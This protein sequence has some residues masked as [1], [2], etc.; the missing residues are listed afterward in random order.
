MAVTPDGAADI[1]ARPPATGLR[2]ALRAFRH[3]DFAIFWSGALVSNTGTW[4]SNLAVPYVLFEIT[5]SVFWLGLAS[6]AQLIPALVLGPL[7][8]ALADRFDRRRILIVTQCCAATSALLMW[9]AWS[10][11]VRDPVVIL[12]LLGLTG[13]ILGINMPSWQSFVNDLVPREDL[14]SAVTLNSV[15]FNAARSLG[16]AIAG[17]LLAALGPSWAFLINGLSFVF[18]L[19]A[20]LFVRASRT[21][22]VVAAR[23]GVLRQFGA[24]LRYVRTQPGIMV[25][26]LVSGVVAL[27]ANPI[28]QFTVVFADSVYHVDAVG[29]GLLNMAFG[30]GAIVAAPIVSGGNRHLTLARTV[31]WALV[32]YAVAVAG[33]AL[34][35]YY[36]AGL[37]CL[38]VIGACFL[39]VVSI[40]NTAT[41]VIVADQMRGRV[42]ALRIMVF[43]GVTPVGGVLQGWLADVVGPRQTVTG[44]G[45][46]LLAATLLLIRLRGRVRLERLD[47]P[48]D[49]GPHGDPA[50]AVPATGR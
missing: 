9:A 48:H 14:M 21:R 44:A 10:S 25:G 26:F 40:A 12:A 16:P 49:E 29:L 5:G 6:F 13:V 38:A 8:G 19:S 42:L 17:A 31:K 30:V 28:F 7:G 1:S 45:L 2:H 50:Q 15:Q 47:D 35:P 23:A 43:T 20:L 24:A 37:V 22:V 41:Q 3:R 36:A 46:L 34:L 33:F 27:L 39:T 32:L 11:G 4:L 18:V